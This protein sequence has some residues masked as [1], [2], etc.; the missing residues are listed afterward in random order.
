MKLNQKTYRRMI[1][2]DL[3]W[4]RKAAEALGQ[5]NEGPASELGH[6]IS[7]LGE[8]EKYYYEKG[9]QNPDLNKGI[10]DSSMM[11]ENQ[12]LVWAAVWAIEYRGYIERQRSLGSAGMQSFDTWERDAA[13]HA[14]EHA[15][16]AVE[17][18]S[19]HRDEFVKGWGADDRMTKMLDQMVAGE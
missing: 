6:I 3:V 10:E 18:M 5:T 15:G 7:I 9:G 13:V 2:E 19:K 11:N 1:Q 12:K 17:S 4:L 8:S 14:T 16:S